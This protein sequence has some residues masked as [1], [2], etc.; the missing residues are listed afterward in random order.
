MFGDP[1]RMDPRSRLFRTQNLANPSS[2]RFVLFRPSALTFGI[3]KRCATR[4]KPLG[5][6]RLPVLHGSRLLRV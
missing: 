5:G 6:G 2:L 4:T 3:T 1:Q